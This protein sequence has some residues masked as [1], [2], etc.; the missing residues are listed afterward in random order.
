MWRVWGEV[1]RLRLKTGEAGIVSGRR[2]EKA[3]SRRAADRLLVEA[4]LLVAC[5]FLAVV[6]TLHEQLQG[7]DLRWARAVAKTLLEM[8]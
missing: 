7:C 1:G 5:L 3:A 8:R 2:M 4:C 6:V